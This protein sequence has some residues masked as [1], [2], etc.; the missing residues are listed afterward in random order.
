MRSA[1]QGGDVVKLASPLLLGPGSQA[2][3]SPVSHREVL[4]PQ[5]LWGDPGPPC[6]RRPPL[7]NWDTL[8][9][10]EALG[11][12]KIRVTEGSDALRLEDTFISDFIT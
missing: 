1:E 9:A 8:T 5:Q 2:C 11:R 3:A 10:T 6:T 12:L 4:P 7:C